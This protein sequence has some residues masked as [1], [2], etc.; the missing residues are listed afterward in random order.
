V[1]ESGTVKITALTVESP[2]TPAAESPGS[3]GAITKN[4]G[5]HELFPSMSTKISVSTGR[6][7]LTFTVHWSPT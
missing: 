4:G 2:A 6:R 7:D 5:G 1:K 3:V